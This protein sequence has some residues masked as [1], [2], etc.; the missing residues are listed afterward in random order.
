M[1]ACH[2]HCFSVCF[3]GLLNQW[4]RRCK[5]FKTNNTGKNSLKFNGLIP[6]LTQNYIQLT[7]YS[8]SVFIIEMYAIRKQ[9]FCCVTG[10]IKIIFMKL[11]RRKIVLQGATG[12]MRIFKHFYAIC[13]KN[14]LQSASNSIFSEVLKRTFL[15]Y[16]KAK[17]YLFEGQRPKGWP[18]KLHYWSKFMPLKN[19]FSFL[20][21]YQ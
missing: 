14:C 16:L 7:Q 4:W 21:Q 12:W 1:Y 10:N 20:H 2:W 13:C 3:A 17:M 5:V 19:S 9:I 6:L 15:K 11:R 18:L 8:H